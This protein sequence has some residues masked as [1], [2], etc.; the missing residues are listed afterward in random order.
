M[1]GSTV[2]VAVHFHLPEQAYP[3]AC[4]ARGGNTTS[5]VEDGVHA[6][7]DLLVVPT[8]AVVGVFRSCL[9]LYVYPPVSRGQRSVAFGLGSPCGA[10]D[11]L[12][13]PLR[14]DSLVD[15]VVDVVVD[16]WTRAESREP[17]V[18]STA[19]TGTESTGTEY[20]YWYRVLVPR[21]LVQLAVPV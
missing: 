19:S 5:T 15:V 21:V 9:K 8:T 20:R 7:L 13:F 4:G 2:H 12:H 6:E 16:K 10:L 17:R 1:H 14:L 11:V 18:E 3:S